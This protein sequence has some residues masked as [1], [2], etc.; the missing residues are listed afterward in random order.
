MRV[1]CDCMIENKCIVQYINLSG[2][3]AAILLYIHSIQGRLNTITKYIYVLSN[4]LCV[5]VLYYILSLYVLATDTDH[6][7]LIQSQKQ[8]ST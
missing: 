3:C 4:I 5:F 6:L 2:S 8:T 7:Y 1:A